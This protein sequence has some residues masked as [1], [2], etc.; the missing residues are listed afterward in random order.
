MDAKRGSGLLNGWGAVIPM[1]WWRAV[2][3]MHVGTVGLGSDIFAHLKQRW[4]PTEGG[5]LV[6]TP[7]RWFLD[8]ISTRTWEVHDG[9]VDGFDGGY[10]AYVLARAER[11]PMASVVEGKRQQLVKKELAW[12]R[13]ERPPAPPNRSFASR[14]PTR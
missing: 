7:D 8:E 2:V 5:L 9:I 6:V 13:A 12:L 10:A 3:E 4:R 1:W 14:Q 11:D